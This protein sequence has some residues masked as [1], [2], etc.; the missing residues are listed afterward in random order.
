MSA[1]NKRDPFRELK[2]GWDAIKNQKQPWRSALNNYQQAYTEMKAQGIMPSP[3]TASPM[4]TDAAAQPNVELG[5]PAMT[6]RKGIQRANAENVVTETPAITESATIETPTQ[7]LTGT[8]TNAQRPALVRDYSSLT[9]PKDLQNDRMSGYRTWLNDINN[10]YGG[11]ILGVDPTTLSPEKQ[12]KYYEDYGLFNTI[13]S[14]VSNYDSEV[15]DEQRKAKEAEEYASTR[16]SL[17]EKY[18]PTTIRAMGY[19]NTG[20]AADALTDI[21]AAYANYALGAKENAN[22]NMSDFASRYQQAISDYQ[23]QQVAN[24]QAEA[25]SL[26]AAQ[27][28]EYKNYLA[29]ILNDPSFDTKQ[30]D[31]ALTLGNIS[32]SQHKD[33]MTKYDE[34]SA[35]DAAVPTDTDSDGNTTLKKITISKTQDQ[36]GIDM[37]DKTVEFIKGG[38]KSQGL[39]KEGLT[40]E[41][42][43]MY[44]RSIL[45]RHNTMD[46]QDLDEVIAIVASG[47]KIPNGT[48]FDINDGKGKDLIVYWNGRFYPVKEVEDIEE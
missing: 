5:K 41:E 11:N 7:T 47:K 37:A 31:T 14:A 15:L 28:T 42:L 2:D 22:Q 10:Y 23:A 38:W 44:S 45:A 16:R 27:E 33:L 35:A 1:P 8:E 36:S 13:Y 26:N 43:A 30:L 39:D 29:G 17:M 46:S 24:K 6:R 25:Q 12:K 21:D 9:A 3:N 32:E 48:I 4:Q 19:A 40:A 20:L 34:K 18:L